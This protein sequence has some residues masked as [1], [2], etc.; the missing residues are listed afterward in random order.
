[1]F[2]HTVLFHLKKGLPQDAIAEF[3]AA[4]DSLKAIKASRATYIGTVAETKDRPVVRSD[5]SYNL[6]ILFDDIEGHNQYQVDPLH[7][8][9]VAQCSKYWTHIEIIDSD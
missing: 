1:M 6:T 7:K 8:A 2:V 4:L 9:F 5:Y 3:E